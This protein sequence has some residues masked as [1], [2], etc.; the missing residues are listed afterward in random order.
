[1]MAAGVS[2]LLFPCRRTSRL[3][4]F[5]IGRQA[6]ADALNAVKP[7]VRGWSE[8]KRG[9]AGASSAHVPAPRLFRI[10]ERAL[11]ARPSVIEY[12]AAIFA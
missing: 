5:E 11:Y 7:Y 12:E 2:I 8:G 1:M 4:V 9:G 6:G 10:A 3:E